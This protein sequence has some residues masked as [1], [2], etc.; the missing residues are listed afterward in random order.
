MIRC[1]T[2]LSLITACQ[3][4]PL[5]VIAERSEFPRHALKASRILVDKLPADADSFSVTFEDSIELIG[6]LVLP[7][8]PKPGD[9]LAI[10]TYYRIKKPLPESWK[11]F[12]HVDGIGVSNRMHGDHCPCE[13]RY[14]TSYWQPGEIIADTAYVATR[15]QPRADYNLW[16]GLYIDKRRM[17]ISAADADRKDSEN[18]A[19]IA[20]MTLGQ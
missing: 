8:H 19:K 17:K 16:T 12:V 2:F 18:R 7:K 3:P 20:R 1:L 4:R 5:D 14:P 9:E 11:F 10:T 15:G 6:A 13:G